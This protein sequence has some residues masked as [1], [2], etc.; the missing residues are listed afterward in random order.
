MKARN[1]ANRGALAVPT[2]STSNDICAEE[3]KTAEA[4]P[5]ASTYGFR[6][7]SV[8]STTSGGS[9]KCIVETIKP[10]NSVRSNSAGSHGSRLSNSC[11]IK[12]VKSP[13]SIV[14]GGC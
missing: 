9:C 7:H 2:K 4:K 5:T 8:K 6:S 11:S 14:S 1:L 13:Q 12:S 3:T 10:E